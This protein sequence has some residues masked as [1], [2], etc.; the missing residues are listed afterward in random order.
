MAVWVSVPARPVAL[1]PSEHWRGLLLVDPE[2]VADGLGLIVLAPHESAA[3][4]VA[5][6]A[7]VPAG[8]GGLAVLAHGPAAQA[9][10]DVVA[11]DLEA[12]HRVQGTIKAREHALQSLGLGDRAD[13]AVEDHT[14]LELAASQ[15]LADDPEDHIVRH[16]VPAVHVL[17][18]LPAQR[19]TVAH[20]GAQHV[21]R[22]ERGNPEG[23]GELRGLRPFTR[24]GLAEE[25]DVH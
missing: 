22:G 5:R 21:A 23:L 25:E 3:A 10:D 1:V 15:R 9:V 7:G 16:E 8:V 24:A 19:G 14:A 12:E 17:L 4:L 11:V 2:T 6:T 20:R 13:D 18:R